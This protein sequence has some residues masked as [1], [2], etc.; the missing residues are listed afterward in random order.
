M[1]TY[2]SNESQIYHRE[3]KDLYEALK[4]YLFFNRFVLT[5]SIE[6]TIFNFS[7]CLTVALTFWS[8]KVKYIKEK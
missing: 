3:I 2:W 7:I 6:H 4:T 1:L 8:N 5:A